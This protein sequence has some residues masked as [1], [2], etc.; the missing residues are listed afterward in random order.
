MQPSTKMQPDICFACDAYL[1]G[2]GGGELFNAKIVDA[3]GQLGINVFVLTAEPRANG[4]NILALS[5]MKCCGHRIINVRECFQFMKRFRPKRVI[6]SGPSINDIAI[7]SMAR[8]L[9]IPFDVNYIGELAWNSLVGKIVL[10]L[11]RGLV[12][13]YAQRIFTGNERLKLRLLSYG[14]DPE[15]IYVTGIGC[16]IVIPHKRVP[17]EKRNDEIVFVGGLGHTHAYKRP[18]LLLAAMPM[19]KSKSVYL[20]II[21]KGDPTFLKTLATEL[22][23]ADRV[24]F[25][26]PLADE[27]K[28]K[29]VRL[30][31]ALILPSPTLREGFG[32]VALESLMYGTP[33][34]IGVEAGAAEVVER[35]QFGVTW[36]GSDP[37]FLANAINEVLTW[38]N[39]LLDEK[40]TR[41]QAIAREYSWEAMTERFFRA[42]S[43]RART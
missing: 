20:R 21:G 16:D 27:E 24:I 9:R 3:L 33:V 32:I 1:P 43:A 19:L 22:G 40:F 5:I 7:A 42:L 17:L 6:I 36:E 25:A 10:T 23:I 14:V 2:L 18:D 41:F 38:K 34:V 12:W 15:K 26:G 4:K 11:M 30:A 35:S 29:S 31:R 28:E 8:Y 13:R 39:P 37:Q